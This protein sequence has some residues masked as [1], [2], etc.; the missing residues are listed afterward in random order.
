[1]MHLTAPRSLVARRFVASAPVTVRSRPFHA[2]SS[3]LVKVGDR[4]PNLE[5]VED[6]PGNQVNLSRE[7]AQGKGV[8][9]G[10]P[11]AFSK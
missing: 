11:A 2:T 8:I 5:L 9:I 1:M 7:L 6:S 3:V 10:V 4:I